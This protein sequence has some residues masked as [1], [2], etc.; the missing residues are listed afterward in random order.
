MKWH[1]KPTAGIKNFTGEEGS[2]IAGEDPDYHV[3][4]MFNAIAQGNY[5]SWIV[6][7]QV[8]DPKD[9]ETVPYDIFD[10]T[11]IWPHKDYP[12]QPIG[13]MTLNRNPSNYFQDVEQAAFS[14][15]TMVPGIGPSADIMLQARMFSYP[16]AQ[17]YRVGA[18]YQ[19]LPCN[20]AHSSVYSPY[21]RDGPARFDGN[22]GSDPDYVRS[23]FRPIK[24]IKPTDVSF[25]E[26][27]GHVQQYSSEVTDEDWVQ[28]RELWRIFKEE[29]SDEDFIHNVSMHMSGAIKQVQDKAIEVWG[30]VDPEISQRIRKTLDEH[31]KIKDADPNHIW[32]PSQS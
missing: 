17:R 12:L 23:S 21:Q 22:Y 28:P 5:P 4:D 31:P 24:E 10:D 27:H 2:R 8:M 6:N 1:F 32:T 19:Q 3:R 11:K 18:N 13:K 15:S 7:I 20:A 14:P 16:D 30:K 9:A 26:W 25:N 29:K